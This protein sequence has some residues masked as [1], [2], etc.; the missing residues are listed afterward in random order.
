MTFFLFLVPCEDFFRKLAD[1]I[2]VEFQIVYPSNEKKPTILLSWIGTRPEL[3]SILLN[4]HMDVVPVFEEFWT[5]KPFDADMDEEGRIFARGTQ[6]MKSVGM[7]YLAAIHRFK[8]NKVSLERTLHVSFVPDEENFGPD[9]MRT[10]AVSD[11]FKKLNVGFVMDEGEL[12]SK[13]ILKCFIN[14]YL[15]LQELHRWMRFSMFIMA[16]EAVGVSIIFQEIFA[17]ILSLFYFSL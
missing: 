16:N 3:S 1:E 4:S 17:N 12:R 8:R 11:A 6:D 9:G 7:Q 13:E 2:G 10:F 5:H 14:F 15:D